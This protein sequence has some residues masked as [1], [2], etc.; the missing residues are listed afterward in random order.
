MVK[1]KDATKEKKKRGRPKSVHKRLQSSIERFD[2]NVKIYGDPMVVIFKGM[3]SK[4][5][6]RSKGPTDK[7]IRCAEILMRYR[8]P[9][10]RA[11][12]V[13]QEIDAKVE[14]SWA[15]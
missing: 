4:G 14:F 6:P 11:V 15:K 13:T 10:L 3:R 8:H 7:Q 5:T 2:K 12:E 9:Q 1:K